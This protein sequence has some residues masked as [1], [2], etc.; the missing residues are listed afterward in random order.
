MCKTQRPSLN[1]T[2][3]TDESGRRCGGRRLGCTGSGHAIFGAKRN[4]PANNFSLHGLTLNDGCAK[5]KSK[6]K[7]AGP[8]A[9]PLGRKQ[10]RCRILPD[11]LVYNVKKTK[12]CR[13]ASNDHTQQPPQSN[14]HRPSRWNI[15]AALSPKC[16]QVFLVSVVL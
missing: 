9:A 16:K 1:C 15:F 7:L 2:K 8:K 11:Q 5:S 10:M 4:F 12:S 13:T 6:I 3:S 14:C